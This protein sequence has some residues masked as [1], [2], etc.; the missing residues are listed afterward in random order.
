MKTVLIVALSIVAIIVIAIKEDYAEALF[1]AWFYSCCGACTLLIIWAAAR[2]RQ[3]RRNR[4]YNSIRLQR[5]IRDM[6][7][8]SYKEPLTE[9]EYESEAIRN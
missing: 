6:Q 8:G 5:Q 4:R 3:C 7:M 9:Y 1:N 2:I